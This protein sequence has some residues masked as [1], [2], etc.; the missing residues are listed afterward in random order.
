MS[1]HLDS[2]NVD[3]DVDGDNVDDDAGGVGSCTLWPDVCDVDS[4]QETLAPARSP[5][6]PM[7]YLQPMVSF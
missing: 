6:Y 2:P 3:V 7:R 5:N 1:V 4:H